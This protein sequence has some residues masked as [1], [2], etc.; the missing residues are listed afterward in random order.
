MDT[1]RYEPWPSRNG[2]GCSTAGH[3]TKASLGAEHLGGDGKVE[4]SYRWIYRDGRGCAQLIIIRKLKP[5]SIMC[6]CS[7]IC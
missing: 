3:K 7:D 5:M 6:V 1:E 4:L 2:S